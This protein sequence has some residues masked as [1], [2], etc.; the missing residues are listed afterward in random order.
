MRAIRLLS[1]AVLLVSSA[2]LVAHN[3]GL[4]ALGC[5]RNRKAAEYH[6]HTGALAG[7]SFASKA[8]AV[9]ASGHGTPVASTIGGATYGVAK[10]VLLYNLRF[11]MASTMA[12]GE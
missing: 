3:G 6:C 10:D 7:R 8:E 2:G 5:H 12:L 1:C 4:D 9:T 11:S